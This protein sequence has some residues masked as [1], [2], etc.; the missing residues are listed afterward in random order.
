MAFNILVTGGA[1]YLGS[2]LV[3]ELLAANHNVT[4]IDN[5]MY[6]QSSLNHVCYHPNLKL[7][8]GDIRIENSMKSLLKQADIVIPLAAYVGAPLCSKDPVGA[9]SVNHDAILMMLKNL[10]HQQYLLMPTTNSAYGKGDEN[11]YCTEDSP[12]RPISQYAIKKVK[13]EKEIM[14]H[15]NAISFR[16]AT[17]FGMSPRM[18]IDLLVNDFTYRAVH[19]RF[20]VLFE[21][22]FKRN[23][24][25]VK[26]VTRVFLHAIENFDS[27][28]G[29]IF[30]VGLSDAN[31]S[32]KELCE[33]IKMQIP[34]FI[35]PE[36][37]IGTDPD[38][39][40]YIV[41]N[42]KIEATGFKP[43]YSVDKGISDL[44]K[45]YQMIKN[46]RYGNV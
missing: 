46:T 20:V 42:T 31:I 18:R 21:P 23:Y 35:F 41:S 36:A 12:L 22:H 26:D 38:Q 14:Q 15:E 40:D 45:G 2:T 16:L 3:P 25:H 8:R 37:I 44:I 11:N 10:S 13:I 4:V 24:I 5:F 6:G 30:N 34:D 1:G 43:E 7:I 32:K 17:V 28:R 19:D 33:A 29:D 9:S 39:R 27:M